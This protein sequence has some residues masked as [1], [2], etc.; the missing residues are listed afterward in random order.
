L[1]ERVIEERTLEPGRS[2]QF[3]AP[4]NAV[5]QRPRLAVRINVPGHVQNQV[6]CEEALLGDREQPARCHRVFRVQ[7]RSSWTAFVTFV[8]LLED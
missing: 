6:E 7:N 5:T 1:S 3:G 4:F 8:E 2:T